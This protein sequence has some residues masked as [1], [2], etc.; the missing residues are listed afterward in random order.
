MNV[1]APKWPPTPPAL[2]APRETQGAP[3][4]PRAD[5]LM[6]VGGREMAPQVLQAKGATPPSNSPGQR[7]SRPGKPRALL[8]IELSQTPLKHSQ[9]TDGRR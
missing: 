1:G 9:D 7:S 5:L 4:S 8:P 2:G 6:N 3:R